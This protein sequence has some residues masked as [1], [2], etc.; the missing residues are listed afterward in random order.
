MHILWFRAWH[1]SAGIGAS[2]VAVLHM[3]PLDLLKIKFQVSTR[4]SEGGIGRGIWCA[5]CDIR[6]SEDGVGY[7]AD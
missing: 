3:N 5:L 1:A 2:T 6:A 7:I 4:G